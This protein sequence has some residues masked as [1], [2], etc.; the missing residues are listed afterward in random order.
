[1]GKNNNAQLDRKVDNSRKSKDSNDSRSRPQLKAKKRKVNKN[2]KICVKSTFDG[3]QVSVNSDDE[4][5][6]Y[7]DD[8][9]DQGEEDEIDSMDE[10][11]MVAQNQAAQARSG[12]Q[13]P[14][15]GNNIVDHT[16]NDMALGT[17][18]ASLTDEELVMN[19]P[20]L[21]KLLNKMLDERILEASKRGESS[22]SQLLTKMTPQNQNSAG[23]KQKQGMH[24]VKSPLD[25]TIYIPALKCNPHITNQ[26]G[27]IHGQFKDLRNNFCGDRINTTDVPKNSDNSEIVINKNSTDNDPDLMMKFSNFVDQITLQTDQQDEIVDMGDGQ[28]PPAMDR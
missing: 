19:N 10:D 16:E 25:T 14:A 11:S 20:H 28:S 13:S 4:E 23:K 5:L 9:L 27:L 12:K 26:T 8:L 18:S 24:V 22:N 7:E 2:D 17:S 3:I 15:K 1:M 21:R 6:D